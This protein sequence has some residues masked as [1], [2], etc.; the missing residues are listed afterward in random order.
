MKE[1]EKLKMTD[2]GRT[3]KRTEYPALNSSPNK[4][5]IL[6]KRTYMKT[7]S[8]QNPNNEPNE[9]NEPNKPS[10]SKINNHYGNQIRNNINSNNESL[11]KRV[12][13]RTILCMFVCTS[14]VVHYICDYNATIGF[15][16]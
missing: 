5:T 3:D 15:Q 11:M 6:L 12:T 2:M 16:Y 14:S 1:E 9:P 13:V 8:N 4:P 7:I 10:T